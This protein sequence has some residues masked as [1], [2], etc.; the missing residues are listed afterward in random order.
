VAFRW[1][2]IR[3]A[4]IF[5]ATPA[6]QR[7]YTHGTASN[8]ARCPVNAIS[9]LLLL[10]ASPAPVDFDTEVLPVLTKAGCNAGACHGAASGRGG[11][12]LSLFGGDPA[13]DHR[14]IAAQFEGRRVNLARPER[15]LLLLKPTWQLDHEGGQRFEE[16]SAEAR[17]LLNWI[18]D[19]A[20]RQ[21][22]R[23]LARLSAHAE[24]DAFEMLPA[25]T[26]LAVTARFD[27][28]TAC[29][30]DGLAVYAPAD[31]AAT[32]VDAHGNVKVL[33][34]G[35]HA[36]VVRFLTEAVAVQL[37]AA[38]AN[39]PLELS[40][41]PRG[42]WIDDEIHGTLA[43]LRLPPSPPADDA[44]LLRRVTLDLTGRLPTPERI[45]WY[46]AQTSERK[47]ETEVD[48][49]L[50]S[51]EFT[52]YWTY[53]LWHWL[54]ADDS[55]QL[56]Q[57]RAVF[58]GWLEEQIAAARPLDE[59]TR[60]MLVA[61]GDS[62]EVGPAN[63]QRLAADARAQAEHV[64]E[65]LL[66]IRLRCANC[67]NHPLDRWTQDDY[68]GLAAIFARV[69]RGDV[70]KLRPSGEVTH[71]VTGEAAIPKIPG[72]EFLD[73][74]GDGRLA[75]AD[76]LASKENPY[77]ARAWVNRLWESLL[78]RGLV[79]PSDDLR[80]T[81]PATHSALLD[82]LA[83]DFAANQFRIRHTLRLIAT[84][85]AYQRSGRALPENRHDARY[86]SHAVAR[87]LESGVLIKAVCQVTGVRYE[88]L[89]IR[90][91][92]EKGMMSR[93]PRRSREPAFDPFGVAQCD[94]TRLA[95]V[96]DRIGGVAQQTGSPFALSGRLEW[97][98]GDLINHRLDDMD[99]ELSRLVRRQ[100]SPQRLVE[101]Y[102]LRTLSRLPTKAESTFWNEE[103]AR[104]DRAARCEDFAWA[105]LSCEEFVTNH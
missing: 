10:A 66:A 72:G 17:L 80:D 43:E 89:V 95:N 78:G 79:H 61:T 25:E 6:S 65:S 31:P 98:A 69:E 45:R 100:V 19:G 64:V 8:F 33:L 63:F 102:Y 50:G 90:E 9:L 56:A 60:E 85:A 27:D 48:R 57:S 59:W 15:S 44:T 46:L 76:W 51:R 86:Y 12:K 14:A 96:G 18:R 11:F 49:L 87:P 20:A 32:E 1:V 35:R 68:H 94:G 47:L 3:F 53:K 37:T 77:F 73:A 28:G 26:S 99:N 23:R 13:A 84:S 7:R 81:N 104:G 91:R 55:S 101:E 42:N 70:V 103:L 29:R 2:S 36:I 62:S 41:A 71:P 74:S 24:Q 39:P 88:N 34:P 21:P 105:L 22:V 16:D 38:F 67:H 52:E 5:L 75:L 4:V 40:A 58:Y 82:R 30:V 93:T 54:G 92:G 97:L 83:S